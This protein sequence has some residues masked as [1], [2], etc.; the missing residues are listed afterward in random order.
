MQIMNGEPYLRMIRPLTTEKPCL[1]CHAKQGYN[2]GDM[3][4]G[5][6]VSVPLDPLRHAVVDERNTLIATHLVLWLAS[7]IGIWLGWRITRQRIMERDQARQQVQTLSGLLPIC[8]SCKRIRDEQGE[9][10]RLESYI[11]KRSQAD[12]S[13]AICPECSRKLYPELHED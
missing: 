3:R 2:L 12:F 7:L 10:Q 6:S 11:S 13:H 5:I 9:W 4:G 1:A 8:A